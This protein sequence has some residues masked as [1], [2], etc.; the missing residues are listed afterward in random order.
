MGSIFDSPAPAAAAAAQLKRLAND[1][2]GQLLNVLTLG[3][4]ALW[5]NRR[6]TPD[7]ILAA[8]GTDAAEV[9]G[10]FAATETLAKQL[11]PGLT[12]P[13]APRAFTVNADGTVTLAPVTPPAAAPV[14]SGQ[15]AGGSAPAAP[16]TPAAP[17]AAPVEA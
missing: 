11:K 13:A 9:F 3:F 15:E 7:E 2:L 10:A 1:Q 17:A 12:L 14:G 8:L 16:A 5:R 6:A 4:A